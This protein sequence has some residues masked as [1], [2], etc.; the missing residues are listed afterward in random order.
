MNKH[1]LEDA[2]QY[3]DSWLGFQY[4]NSR[5][6]GFAV[7]VQYDGKVVF[8]KA[9]GYANLET[10][11]ELTPEHIFRIVSRTP[12]FGHFCEQLMAGYCGCFLFGQVL[13]RS[14]A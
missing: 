1:L 4:D 5:L 9:Y 2:L 11:E 13:P 8:S 12:F 10:K 6:P 3:V 14:H 7:A